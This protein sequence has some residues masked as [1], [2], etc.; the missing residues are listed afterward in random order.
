MANK[1]TDAQARLFEE[2]LYEFV[3]NEI[4]RDEI[5]QGLMAKALVEAD[6]NYEKARAIYIGHR[7][8]SLLDEAELNAHN[9]ERKQTESRQQDQ[10]EKAKR[11]KEQEQNRKK[12]QAREQRALTYFRNRKIGVRKTNS[13]WT[14]ALNDGNKTISS[15]DDLEAY[16]EEHKKSVVNETESKAFL[17]RV[18]KSLKRKGYFAWYSYGSWCLKKNTD[19]NEKKY[20]TFDEFRVQVEGI[21][22]NV[23]MTQPSSD[24]SGCSKALFLLPFVLLAILL[25]V[26][27]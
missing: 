25:M 7:V 5:R 9:E 2:Q 17:R 26:M 23:D 22:G 3:A 13:G 10:A 16:V 24:L 21:L 6:G 4:A 18:S 1:K 11:H 20:Q 8:Q 27:I 12:Q 15:L 14:L 19:T